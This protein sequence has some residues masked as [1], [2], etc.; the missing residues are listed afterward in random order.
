MA[1][2]DGLLLDHDGVLLTLTDR[3]TLQET[4]RAAL[5]D[6]GVDMASPEPVESALATYDDYLAEFASLQ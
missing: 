6:A 2:Y 1:D 5:R 4:A 3:S